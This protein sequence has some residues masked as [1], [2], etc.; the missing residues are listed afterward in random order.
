MY[1]GIYAV[2]EM[3][4]NRFSLRK[5]I[6]YHVC[7]YKFVYRLKLPQDLRMMDDDKISSFIK[8]NPLAG[9][10]DIDPTILD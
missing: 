8:L 9:Q 4:K 3:R 5:S 1:T 10:A 2:K 7:V 6:G